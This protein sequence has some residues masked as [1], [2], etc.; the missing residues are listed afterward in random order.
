[1]SI[2][3][4]L[5]GVDGSEGAAHALR[6]A[7]DLARAVDAEVILVHIISTP[8][9][10]ATDSFAG[11]AAF[12]A[13]P[14]EVFA[15][16]RDEARQQAETDWAAPLA[17]AHVRHRVIIGEGHAADSIITTAIEEN[18]DL[19]VVGRRGHGGFAELILGSVSHH[20]TH[21]ARRPVVVVPGER[22]TRRRSEERR[23]VHLA[24]R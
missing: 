1:M 13:V 6:W 14:Y 8:S 11:A 19:I 7:A 9:G 22:H 21:H 18:A 15:T 5:V 12:S 17:Q 2:Q 23:K 24:T 16:W 10:F 20:L 4:I 3:R